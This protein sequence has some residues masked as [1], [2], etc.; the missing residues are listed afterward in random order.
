MQD[1]SFGSVGNNSQ[2]EPVTAGENITRYDHSSDARFYDYYAR[3]SVTE[4]AA[5]RFAAIRDLVLKVYRAHSQDE[6]QLAV[7]D[8]GCGAGTLCN[9][10]AETGHRV[11]GLDVNEPLLQLARERSAQ[12][13]FEIDYRLGSADALPWGDASMD[14]CIAAELLEHIPS[15]KP[16]LAEFVR[17]LRPG[18]VLYISTSNKLCPKQNEFNLPLYS[19][20]PGPMKQ[21]FQRLAATTRPDLANFAT[22]P[23]VNW[24][25]FYGLRSVLV[26]AG[27][28]CYDLF[29]LMEEARY[30]IA[31]RIMISVIRALPP[32]RWLAHVM[33][34]STTVVAYKQRS[35]HS[36]KSK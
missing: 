1:D 3:E 32:I 27:F 13:G 36:E 29:D 10:W 14:V 24:F 31:V 18:G 33:T 11:H 6:N 17:V 28:R 16:C 12:S 2:S 25:S 9:S 30:N 19:W 5:R 7:V 34:P 26:Q 8:I 35:P 22:Y 23:A 15:W 20:Y 4:S 21:H